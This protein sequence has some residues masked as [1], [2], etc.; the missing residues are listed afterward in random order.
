VLLTTNVDPCNGFFEGYLMMLY[1]LVITVETW[2][3]TLVPVREV[4]KCVRNIFGG[5]IGEHG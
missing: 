4:D 1:E 5:L 2:E 3:G